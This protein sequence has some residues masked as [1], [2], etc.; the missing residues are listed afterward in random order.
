MEGVVLGGIEETDCFE[1]RGRAG[2]VVE[3]EF[4]ILGLGENDMEG[5][6]TIT[7][8]QTSLPSSQPMT[9]YPA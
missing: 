7:V 9:T 8:F 5:I 6:L 2:V 4:A 1:G 3:V